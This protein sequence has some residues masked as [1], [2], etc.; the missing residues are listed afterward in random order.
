MKYAKP[1]IQRK[2][3]R[4]RIAS[5]TRQ[6]VMRQESPQSRPNGLRSK[7]ETS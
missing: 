6:T 1:T 4:Y 5:R 3:G 2:K 7:F